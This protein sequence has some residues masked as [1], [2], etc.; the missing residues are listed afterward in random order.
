MMGW[1]SITFV[2]PCM[3]G[4]VAAPT[5]TPTS[6]T[7]TG[8]APTSGTAPVVEAMALGGSTVVAVATG[9]TGTAV[10]DTTGVAEVVVIMGVVF[11]F[12][13]LLSRTHHVRRD[14]DVRSD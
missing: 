11:K 4:P 9:T 1:C 14:E 5:G 2:G 13:I 12:D 10:V 6:G 3:T 8:A 7:P